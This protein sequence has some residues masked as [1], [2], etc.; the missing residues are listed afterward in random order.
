LREFNI[1]L[2]E[3]IIF[4]WLTLA[5]KSSVTSKGPLL[6]NDK[7]IEDNLKKDLKMAPLK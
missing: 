4:N 2:S 3:G 7:K 6:I 1:L 5:I